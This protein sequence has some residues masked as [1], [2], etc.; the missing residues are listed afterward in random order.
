[1]GHP[2]DW[3]RVDADVQVRVLAISSTTGEAVVV[4]GGIDELSP[5]I[6]VVLVVH[7]LPCHNLVHGLELD[8]HVV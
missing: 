6:V 5:L 8:Q 7:Q 1:M 4:M 2:T 3:T